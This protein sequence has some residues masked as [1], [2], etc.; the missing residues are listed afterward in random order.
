MVDVILAEASR[1]QP[2]QATNTKTSQIKTSDSTQSRFHKS[3]S[4]KED[5]ISETVKPASF[6]NITTKDSLA[7][8]GI[9]SWFFAARFD[10]TSSACLSPGY[11]VDNISNLPYASPNVCT[12]ASSNATKQFHSQK[13]HLVYMH[14]RSHLDIWTEAEEGLHS[15]KPQT[16]QETYLYA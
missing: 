16:E 6:S 8:E 9:C 4:K 15:T 11:F 13:K 10:T 7:Q 12:A 3:C 14:F 1:E 5:N 2:S